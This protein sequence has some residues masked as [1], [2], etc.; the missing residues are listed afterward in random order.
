MQSHFNKLL[1]SFSDHDLH[2]QVEVVRSNSHVDNFA[3]GLPFDTDASHRS[4][5]VGIGSVISKKSWNLQHRRRTKRQKRAILRSRLWVRFERRWSRVTRDGPRR[6]SR[7]HERLL[8]FAGTSQ[9]DGRRRRKL[10][11]SDKNQ[12]RDD[13]DA[14]TACKL[15][16]NFNVGTSTSGPSSSTSSSNSSC[17]CRP[18]EQRLRKS[19]RKKSGSWSRVVAWR[20]C[21]VELQAERQ[22]QTLRVAGKRSERRV[23]SRGRFADAPECWSPEKAISDSSKLDAAETEPTSSFETKRDGNPGRGGSRSCGDLQHQRG[24]LHDLHDVSITDD[25]GRS[26]SGHGRTRSRSRRFDSNCRKVAGRTCHSR[27]WLWPIGSRV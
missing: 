27:A 16:N 17:D 18:Q 12:A 11:S 4:S 19:L 15:F 23:S 13:D 20:N 22:R 3:Q 24:Q 14:A 1:I 9:E 5:N 2:R 10:S 6:Q 25:S 26:S 7:R 21:P 8:H